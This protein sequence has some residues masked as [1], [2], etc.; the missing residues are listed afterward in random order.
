MNIF[1]YDGSP[2]EAQKL[3]NAVAGAFNERLTEIVRT[4]SKEARIF[5]GERL[6]EVK[7]ELEKA[8]KALIEYKGANKVVAITEQTRNFV[9]RQ[10]TLRRMEAENQLALEIARAKLRTPAII[11]DTPVIQQIRNKLAEQEVE[12]ASLLKIYTE[13]HPRVRTLQAALAENKQKLQAELSRLARSEVSLS[14]TQRI[15]LQRINMEEE[16]E[17][18]KIP[19]KERGL[20]RLMRDYTVAEELYTMLAKRYEESRISEVME[21][22]NVQIVDMAALPTDPIKPRKILNFLLATIMGLLFGTMAAFA[23]EFFFKTIDTVD[24][25]KQYLGLPVIGS[26]PRVEAISISRWDAIKSNVRAGKHV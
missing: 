2:S 11:P 3:V 20:A 1:V 4:E 10:S 19:I 12:L 5:I 16:K 6:S 26:I 17:L 14:E 9:D 25:V 13:N 24:D 22:T 23:M 15:A 8:E 18:A 7:R 21:P